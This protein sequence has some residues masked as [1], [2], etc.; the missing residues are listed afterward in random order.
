M[1][2]TSRSALE[3][4]RK[5]RGKE[6]QT[7]NS[8]KEGRR[9]REGEAAAENGQQTVKRQRMIEEDR[10]QHAIIKESAGK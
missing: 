9:N 5:G 1:G 8:R 4:G 7:K 3:M 10:W 6:N 2:T